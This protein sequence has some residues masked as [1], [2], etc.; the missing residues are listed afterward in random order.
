[1]LTGTPCRSRGRVGWGSSSSRVRRSLLFHLSRRAAYCRLT[2][3]GARVNTDWEDHNTE[4][5]Q[6]QRVAAPQKLWGHPSN[7]PCPVRLWTKFPWAEHYLVAYAGCTSWG[8]RRSDQKNSSLSNLG[9][10]SA[11]WA[12]PSG[13]IRRIPPLT[14]EKSRVCQYEPP[15][16]VPG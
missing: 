14:W 13:K 15:R 5:G 8:L 7:L 6:G 2:F 10:M 9:S 11:N 4:G 1:M 3:S 12:L 16:M